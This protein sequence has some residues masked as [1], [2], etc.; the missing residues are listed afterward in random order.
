MVDNKTIVDRIYSIAKQKNIKIGYLEET[1]LEVSVGYFKKLAKSDSM[2]VD[3]VK[4][5]ADALGVTVD[6]LLSEEQ[7]RDIIDEN[8]LLVDYLY[9]ITRL[10]DTDKM[11]WSYENWDE[12]VEKVLGL[13]DR[14]SLDDEGLKF[15]FFTIDY[16]N[17]EDRDTE[18]CRYAEG[19]HG[20]YQADVGGTYYAKIPNTNLFLAVVEAFYTE[21]CEECIPDIILTD[22]KFKY[23]IVAIGMD[24]CLGMNEENKFVFPAIEDLYMSIKRQWDNNNGWLNR[25]VRGELNR[26][27][28]MFNQIKLIE[29]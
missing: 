9:Q 2:G 26:Q 23:D 28:Q 20:T 27:L 4:K 13:N 12:S 24:Y 16:Y 5:A 18:Y 6:Y 3:K 1:I 7:E 21:T 17:P 19:D 10:T 11:I 15:P 25:Q 22:C 8:K 14:T 29:E